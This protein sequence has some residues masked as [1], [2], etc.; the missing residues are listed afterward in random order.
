MLS[1]F[2][3][4]HMRLTGCMNKS[5]SASAR[6]IPEYLVLFPHVLCRSSLDKSKPV[7]GPTGEQTSYEGWIALDNATNRL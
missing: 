6:F 4:I 5:T 7:D 2:A 1:D 3:A